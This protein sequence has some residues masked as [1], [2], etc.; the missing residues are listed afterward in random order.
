MHALAGSRTVFPV[1]T[2][3]ES[4][5]GDL[6]VVAVDGALTGVYFE[7]HRRRPNRATFGRLVDVGFEDVRR[8]FGEYFAGRRREFDLPLAPE[9]D[10][11][12]QRVWKLLLDIPYGETRSYGTLARE[13]GNGVL[14]Q[15]VGAAN[16]RNPL[17]VIVPCHRVVGADGSLVGYAGGLE[18]K[19][20][21]IDLE[22]S[23]LTF[24]L[25]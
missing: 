14:P 10:D 22:Q 3:V 15:A 24:R 20:T 1:H 21:L 7:K 4:P 25:W 16:S 5:V 13:L 18:R 8:Q 23:D 17:S 11:F 19:R 6:T 2:I 12:D 9:G